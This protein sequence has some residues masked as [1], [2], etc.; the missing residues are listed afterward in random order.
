MKNIP[1]NCPCNLKSDLK[2]YED[3]Y[4]CNEKSCIHN[5]ESNSFLIKKKKPILISKEKT[6]TLFE[7]KEVLQDKKNIIFQSI[8]EK[9]IFSH[10]K[11]KS[12]CEK[13]I[14]EIPKNKSNPKILVIGGATKG[15]GTSKLWQNKKLEIHSV[16]IV[17]SKNIDIICDAH[18]LP[19]KSNY[20][21]GVWIQ[22]VLEHV[23]EPIIVVKEIHRV[24]KTKGIVYAETPFMQ[25][26][27]A[28][29]T[30]FTRYTVLGHRFLF[31]DFS[32]ISF[33]GNKGPEL[34]FVWSFKY[35]I[36]SLTRSILL[37]KLIGKFLE[38]LL[39]P[40]AL[41]TSKESMHDASSGVFFLG[42]KEVDQQVTHSQL[43]KLYKGQL[44]IKN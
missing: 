33:G 21:D 11:T 35:L 23:V 1:I 41:F 37:S 30:D 19:L 10:R 24:L 3:K 36:L 17:S 44:D 22:A 4:I 9:L 43:K 5:N 38:L 13:F 42:K 16:D 6:D 29:S 27:H 39:S 34:V 40:L 14:N 20:Y 12:N 8:I 2:R 15:I 25:Q 7:Y 18:Y 28:G 31:K 32:E 26:V